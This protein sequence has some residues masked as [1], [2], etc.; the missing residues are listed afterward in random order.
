[1]DENRFESPLV[2][3]RWFGPP[4]KPLPMGAGA[5]AAAMAFVPGGLAGVGA[6]LAETW[7]YGGVPVHLSIGGRLF[8][9]LL[10]GMAGAVLAVICVALCRSLTARWGIG[11]RAAIVSTIA[12][13]AGGVAVLVWFGIV[14]FAMP[15][16]LW[17]FLTDP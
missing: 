17:D 14:F 6:A 5:V 12:G 7:R 16:E 13:C 9:F 11:W 8:F 1:M 15:S 3:R 10:G 2:L 4:A